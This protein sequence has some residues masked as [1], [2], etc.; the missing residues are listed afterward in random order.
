MNEDTIWQI[1]QAIIVLAAS[2]IVIALVG[3]YCVN[4][5]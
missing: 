5:G 3:W 1:A 4:F 2:F